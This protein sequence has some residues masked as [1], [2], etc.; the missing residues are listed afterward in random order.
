MTWLTDLLSIITTSVTTLLGSLGTGI[1]G[2]AEDLFLNAEGD[3]TVVAGI[4]FVS[5]GLSIALG[6][7]SWVSTLIRNRR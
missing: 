3:L 5:V 2:L 1:V 6:A 4:V 7:V